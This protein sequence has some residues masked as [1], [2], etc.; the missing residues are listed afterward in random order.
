MHRLQN[1]TS[2][3]QILSLLIISYVTLGTLLCLEF[4][5]VHNRQAPTHRFVGE[6]K[7]INAKK[8]FRTVPGKSK[9]KHYGRVRM[10]SLL[11]KE[12]HYEPLRIIFCFF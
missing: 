8:F 2:W 4:P 3:V 7:L 12:P 9:K 10:T 1:W 5:Y 11:N 6:I